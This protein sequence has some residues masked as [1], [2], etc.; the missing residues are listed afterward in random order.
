[1]FARNIAKRMRS[2]CW[3]VD[4]LSRLSDQFLAA[5]R[6]LYFALEY[7]EHLFKVMT[8]WWWA[9]PRW[10]EHVNKGV[11]TRAIPIIRE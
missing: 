10:D 1:M 6:Y 9:A 8:V 4:G 2:I 11:L 5:E 7:A 3:H